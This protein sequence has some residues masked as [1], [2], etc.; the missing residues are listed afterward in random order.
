MAGQDD[1]DALAGEYVLGTLSGDERAAVERRMLDNPALATAIDD[2]QD[3]LSPLATR[4][5]PVIPR[6]EV[7]QR[8][9]R[10]GDRP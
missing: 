5:A 10:F 2:W 7:W 6:P 4:L 3:R 1:L 9:R 8:I